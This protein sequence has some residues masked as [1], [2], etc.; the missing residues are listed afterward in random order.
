[1]KDKLIGILETLKFSV[2]QQ[3]SLGI[4]EEYPDSFFTFWNNSSDGSSFYD[5]KENAYI[6]N[7]DLNF[8]SIDPNL[9][10]TKLLEAVEL[11]KQNGFIA[12]GKGH[13]VMSDEITHTGR[14]I[15]ILKKEKREDLK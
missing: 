3:S 8:Y 14:G 13:D 12:Y 15:N 7:F 4:N 6:W 1:M 11:L 10:N 2:I 9:V 5:N